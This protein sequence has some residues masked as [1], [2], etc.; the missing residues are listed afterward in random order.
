MN[1]GKL[2]FSPSGRIGQKSFWIG[3]GTV[4]LFTKGPVIFMMARNP[5]GV[6]PNMSD[7]QQMGG[8]VAMGALVTLLGLVFLWPMMA[9]AAKR[10]HDQGRSAWLQLIYYGL[11]AC[12]YI[13]S[14]SRT[15]PTTMKAAMENQ[16][17]PQAAQDAIREATINLMQTDPFLH[18]SNY[19]MLTMFVLYGLALGLPKG[20]PG[21][22]KY[23]P[24]EGVEAV[25]TSVV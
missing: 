18:Y 10:L 15:V 19:I 1:I 9:V 23:G 4:F 17:D 8:L 11:Y 5:T 20:T 22:N 21:Q 6:M 12:I 16:G 25:R 13:Y 24:P 2:F 14:M 7:P 3:Y